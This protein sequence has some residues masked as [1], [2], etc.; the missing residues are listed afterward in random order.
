MTNRQYFSYFAQKID[1]FMFSWTCRQEKIS[2][3]L[4]EKSALFGAHAISLQMNGFF[5]QEVFRLHH[6]IIHLR[7]H[8]P[9]KGIDDTP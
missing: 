4:V 7:T 5:D 2:L 6:E 3:I 9:V 8:V 1:F